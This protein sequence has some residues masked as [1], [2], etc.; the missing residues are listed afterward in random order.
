MSKQALVRQDVRIGTDVKPNL[1]AERKSRLSNA[2]F[3]CDLVSCSSESC[4]FAM[5]L[6]LA[7][8]AFAAPAAS[9]SRAAAIND[10]HGSCGGYKLDDI[11]EESPRC[12]QYNLTSMQR[13]RIYGD[14]K[15]RS[16]QSLKDLPRPSLLKDVDNLLW[17]LGQIKRAATE[18]NTDNRLDPF[19]FRTD[20]LRQRVE[21]W[22]TQFHRELDADMRDAVVFAEN[23]MIRFLENTRDIFLDEARAYQFMENAGINPDHAPLIAAFLENA[24]RS[25]V[26]GKTVSRF[27]SNA[28]AMILDTDSSFIANARLQRGDVEAVSQF[29][30]N[31]QALLDE[32]IDSRLRE[33]M[34]ASVRRAEGFIDNANRRT[35]ELASAIRDASFIENAPRQAKEGAAGDAGFIENKRDKKLL[36]DLRAR[37][38]DAPFFP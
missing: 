34:A 5:L 16:F 4:Q 7:L 2:N 38:D 1:S 35:Q 32:K 26:Q 29:I 11:P 17:D 28:R 24:H 12:I 21:N 8:L 23:A 31:V 33:N 20:D 3:F 10:D 15:S 36:F 25:L 37:E 9:V 27:L 13:Q 30:E 22:K 6:P 14:S 19:L 18:A